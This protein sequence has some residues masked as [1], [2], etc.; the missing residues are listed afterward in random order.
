MP[1]TRS[2][3]L[4]MRDG[5]DIHCV[6]YFPANPPHSSI[7]FM[8]G[9]GEHSGRYAHLAAFFCER[10]FAVRTYD[11]RGHGKS[12]GKRG[13]IPHP[14]S[15]LDDAQQVMHDWQASCPTSVTRHL[16]L[17]HSM[18]GLFAAKFA[19]SK[20][21]AL[22]GLILSAPALA[23]Y[24]NFV[25]RSLLKVL[26]AIAPALTLSNGLK[27]TYLSHDPKVVASYL[28][29]PL[30]HD[31]ISARL[32]N[33]M[34]TTMHDVFSHVSSLD[35]PTLLLVAGQDKLVDSTGSLRFAQASP[36]NYLRLHA[37]DN[38]Y[39]EIFN[40]LDA[41]AVFDDVSM[42]LDQLSNTVVQ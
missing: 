8:H 29:D 1:E 30:V 33:S 40:E 21:C 17:G 12:S 13:D 32:L 41:K 4:K 18:G 37:Y 20:M 9:L 5:T 14:D 38:L 3:M 6:D 16:L 26:S 15:L 11:H 35:L 34:L 28:A 7:M 39:H 36:E 27:T 19:L 10:G 42:W 2:L 22:D 31:R 24:M 25:E 23:I